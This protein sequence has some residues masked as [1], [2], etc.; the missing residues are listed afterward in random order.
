MQTYN[1][2]VRAKRIAFTTFHQSIGY[3]EFVEGLSEATCEN[4]R[5][6]DCL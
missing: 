1:E 4:L 2:L 5:K 3:E 6:S